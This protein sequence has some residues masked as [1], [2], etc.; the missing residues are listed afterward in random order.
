MDNLVYIQQLEA[1]HELPG[2]E[3]LLGNIN[4]YHPITRRWK[5]YFYNTTLFEE[6][7]GVKHSRN[8]NYTKLRETTYQKIDEL[9]QSFLDLQEKLLADYIIHEALSETITTLRFIRNGIDFE[10]L[11]AGAILPISDIEYANK[12]KL[13]EVYEAELYG[14]KIINNKNEALICFR[15]IVEKYKKR[16]ERLSISEQKQ[17]KQYITQISKA[18][19]K[20]WYNTHLGKKKSWLYH[21]QTKRF[22][23]RYGKLPIKRELYTQIFRY[24]LDILWLEEI[25]IIETKAQGFSVGKDVFRIPSDSHFD[26]ISVGKMFRLIYHEIVGHLLNWKNHRS[27]FHDVRGKA[28]VMKEEWVS[29]LLESL[30]MW[31]RFESIDVKP[32]SFCR[33]LAGEILE[34]WDFRAFVRLRKKLARW[35]LSKTSASFLRHKINYPRYHVGVQHKD[36]TYVRGLIEV[37]NFIKQWWNPGSL[38]SGKFSLEDIQS[39]RCDFSE[40]S[41]FHP[42]FPIVDIIIYAIMTGEDAPKDGRLKLGPD[43]SMFLLWKYGPCFRMFGEMWELTP[44]QNEKL[45]YMVKTVKARKLYGKHKVKYQPIENIM[46]EHNR[47]IRNIIK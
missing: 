28:S 7:S 15:E 42:A 30:M 10:L 36:V 27:C 13:Q 26:E 38:F 35:K 41:E 31:E 22:F 8:F 6:F 40:A 44:K 17:Y 32:G 20:K 1:L 47:E 29:M 2:V 43:F 46:I 19:Q 25:E 18:L 14:G 21:W 12:L 23:N 5:K 4:I 11:K 37:M 24:S 9:T 33:I 34:G 39:G 16:K 45:L 3:K